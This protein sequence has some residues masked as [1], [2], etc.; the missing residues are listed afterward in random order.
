[1][2]PLSI[3]IK[4]VSGLCN[5]RCTYCFYCDEMRFRDQG[6]YGKMS[7]ETLE[8][9]IRRPRWRA[10]ISTARCIRWKKNTTPAAYACGT[11]FRPTASSFPTS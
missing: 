4:P 2:P 10:R 5:M 9:L 7:P 3:M 1:M 6:P 11:P 8:T